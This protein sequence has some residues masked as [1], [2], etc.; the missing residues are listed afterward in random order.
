M[1]KLLERAVGAMRALYKAQPDHQGFVRVFFCSNIG[2]KVLLQ[3]AFM[4]LEGVG[5]EA[6]RAQAQLLSDIRTVVL[7]ET[8]KVGSQN[9]GTP[10]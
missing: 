8:H 2:W 7:L 5:C 6:E 10:V 1:P 4:M 9:R 3:K